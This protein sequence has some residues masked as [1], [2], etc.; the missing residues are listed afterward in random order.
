MGWFTIMFDTNAWSAE[1]HVAAKQEIDLY[2]K[3]LRSLIRDASLYHVSARPDGVDWDGMEYWDPDRHK[4]VV[5]AF[6]GSIV[7]EKVHSYQ[8]KGLQPWA[9]YRLSYHDHSA[10]DSIASGKELMEQGLKVSLPIPN[11]SE[12]I[13]IADLH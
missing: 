3:E 6:H 1:Q 8:L 11:S 7:E 5:F 12:L 13:F 9:R 4:G 2:K 10:P